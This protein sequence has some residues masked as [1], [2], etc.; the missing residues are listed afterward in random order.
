MRKL[1]TWKQIN[2]AHYG[3]KEAVKEKKFTTL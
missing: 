1:R 2:E 3:F